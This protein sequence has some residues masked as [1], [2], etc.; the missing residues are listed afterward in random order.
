[1]TETA[2]TGDAG[3]WLAHAR[4][5]D[6]PNCD[7]RPPG[8]VVRLIVVHAIS[9]PPG[10]FGGDAIERLFANRL[11]PAQ[12][13]SYR[14][15]DGVRVSA[16]F[17]VRRD[18]TVLQFVSTAMR[19]WHAGVSCWRGNERCNDFSLGIEL[20]GDD[21]HAFADPQYESLSQLLHILRQG[22]PVEEVVGHADIAAGRKTDPGPFFD[23]RRLP[24][25]GDI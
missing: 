17:L 6:S 3:G 5:L 23:W 12:H 13:P 1:M 15:L 25:A 7:A 22:F 8:E 20:E 16:H 18:G 9:L 2:A 19:A 21:M 24:G 10:Q 4:R 14:E 11:D